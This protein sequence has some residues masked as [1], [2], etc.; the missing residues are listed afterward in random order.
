MRQNAGFSRRQ[1]GGMLV[2]AVPIILLIAFVQLAEFDA[3]L[4]II[5]LLD[6]IGLIFLTVPLVIVVT[7]LIV[8]GHAN[9]FTILSL[10]R[11]RT[12]RNSRDLCRPG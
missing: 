3:L 10:R 9:F 4:M 1:R 11:V 2:P 8:V 5:L 6:G 7:L 12:Q